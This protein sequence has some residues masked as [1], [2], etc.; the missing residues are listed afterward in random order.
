MSAIASAALAL[1][2]LGAGGSLRGTVVST[3]EPLAELAVTRPISFGS[4]LSLFSS[5]SAPHRQLVVV[6]EDRDAELARMALGWS[7]GVVVIVT[8]AQARAFARAGFELFEARDS[9]DGR[10]TAYLCENFVCQLPVTDTGAL[11]VLISSRA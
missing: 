1:D 9:I 3:L 8:P 2:A 6:T 5:L 11:A 4:T 10:P 7:G